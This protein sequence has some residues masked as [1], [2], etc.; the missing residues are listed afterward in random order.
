MSIILRPF[1]SAPQLVETMPGG[2]QEEFDAFMDYIRTSRELDVAVAVVEELRAD[3]GL[4]KHLA[5]LLGRSAAAAAAAQTRDHED[6]QA[7]SGEVTVDLEG[8]T[9]SSTHRA[10]A[11]PIP[12]ELGIRGVQEG[13][14][15]CSREAGLLRQLQ[16][17]ASQRARVE[18]RGTSMRPEF[19]D[20]DSD[21]SADYEAM[22]RMSIS[23]L[24]SVTRG[25]FARAEPRP[26]LEEFDCA[27]GASGNGCGSSDNVSSG[28]EL[29]ATFGGG[30]DHPSRYRLRARFAEGD[31]GGG[32]SRVVVSYE[33]QNA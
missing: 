23:E 4:T 29:S 15:R 7:S 28:F 33:R 10:G 9:V 1:R 31:G 21:F 25:N 20:T 17:R 16:E 13:L 6:A 14:M 12:V 27:S 5:E 18:P 30:S 19:E 11:I 3:D 24:A 8:L 22:I 26:S 32:T 2:I